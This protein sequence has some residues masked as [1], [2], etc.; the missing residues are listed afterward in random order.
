MNI[1][2]EPSFEVSFRSSQNDPFE[3]L[4]RRPRN[5]AVFSNPFSAAVRAPI[6]CQ[7]MS[8]E[9]RDQFCGPDLANAWASSTG[10][11]PLGKTRANW[12]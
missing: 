7:A 12:R 9:W 5:R 4:E 6:A 8:S 2:V 10:L 3:M 1:G 11:S